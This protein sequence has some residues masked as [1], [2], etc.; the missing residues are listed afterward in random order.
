M[1]ILFTTNNKIGSR[2]IRWVTG[3]NVSH[4]AI[5]IDE[6]IYH[7]TMAGAGMSLAWHDTFTEK[8]TV[9][10]RVSLPHCE[11]LLGRLRTISGEG[12]D[13]LLLFTLGLRRLGLLV[14]LIDNPYRD[15]CTEVITEQVLG[16]KDKLTPGELRDKL[17]EKMR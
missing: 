13:W 11:K 10:D 3:E 5:Q 16:I 9:V 15:I 14:P 6:V 7:S 8:N 4:V 2:L 17:M 12:Y 1:N